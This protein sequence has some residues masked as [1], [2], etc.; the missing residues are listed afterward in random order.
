MSAVA[1]VEDYQLVGAGVGDPPVAASAGGCP[2]GID[3]LSPL[4]A[5]FKQVTPAWAKAWFARGE[6]GSGRVYQ[7]TVTTVADIVNTALVGWERALLFR[8][9]GHAEWAVAAVWLYLWC[10][11]SN[12]RDY[13]CVEVALVE[14]PLPLWVSVLKDWL[15]ALRRCP[16]IYAHPEI[17]PTDVL[18]LRALTSMANRT[19]E[20]ADWDDEI[21]K[22]AYQTPVHFGLTPEGDL[23]RAEWERLFS[24]IGREFA[25]MVVHNTSHAASL[26][27]IKD[28]WA[29]RWG[30]TPSGASSHGHLLDEIKER[31]PRL[32]ALA[33]AN[34]K[35]VF[36]ELPST[37]ANELITKQPGA[38]YRGS[39]KP[40]PGDKHRALLA[41]DDDMYIVGSYASVHVEKHMCERGVRAKQTPAD[42]ATWLQYDQLCDGIKRWLSLDYSDFNSEHEAASLTM[43]NVYLALEW[44]AA[45][46]DELHGEKACCALWVA[47]AHQRRRLSCPKGDFRLVGGLCSGDRDTARDNTLLHAIYS[48]IAVATAQVFD[49]QCRSG[50]PMF[51]GDDEDH[52]MP[53]WPSC[54]TYLMA[55]CIM[56]FSMK[57]EKQMCSVGTHEF[58][59]LLVVDHA[60][61]SRGLASAIAQ[62]AS[63]Q[64]Y[65]DVMLW[66]PNITASVSDNVWEMVRRG[67]PL[68]LARRL[69]G[70]HIGAMMRVPRP[71]GEWHQLEWWT[72]RHGVHGEHP[73]WVGT[74]GATAVLPELT[75]E[76]DPD[77]RAHGHATED[78]V[79]EKK[80]VISLPE[81]VWT[82]YRSHCRREGYNRLYQKEKSKQLERAVLR[83]WPERHSFQLDYQG[84]PAT[85]TPPERIKQL[86]QM[87]NV[88]RRPLVMSTMLARV[89]IDARL[90]GLAGGPAKVWPLL[91]TR[92]QAQ[93]SFCSEPAQPPLGIMY[94]D[95]QI[96]A[97]YCLTER[98]LAKAPLTRT[99]RI[100]RW[101]PTTPL[102]NP[103]TVTS[104]GLQGEVHTV[105]IFM[106]PNGCGKSTWACEHPL[107][108][109]TDEFCK[110]SQL[111]AE[112]HADTGLWPEL[113]TKQLV[114][115]IET[116]LLTRGATGIVTQLRLADVLAAPESRFFTVRIIVLL[117]TIEELLVRTASRGWAQ[118]KVLRRYARFLDAVR[119]SFSG[120]VLSARERAEA[121]CCPDWPIDEDISAP[122]SPWHSVAEGVKERWAQV[123]EHRMRTGAISR[124][125]QEIT[126]LP[127]LEVC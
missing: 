27:S 85:P 60:V 48:N 28:W 106:G 44:L 75:I 68:I 61:P 54:V 71:N 17:P 67:M 100:D 8:N 65:K 41:A 50:Y 94:Y 19:H 2:I 63:G 42:V 35:A 103:R 29:A 10:L 46:A 101:W 12:L 87:E 89:G 26:S 82:A 22:R 76:V 86:L 88:E 55:H 125:G 3:A 108:V 45:G 90:V 1:G 62:F 112:V 57:A 4:M 34:K 36:E 31:D 9:A 114:P 6:S 104:A 123:Q 15:T 122:D 25:R 121:R 116:M 109:D 24:S 13:L 59:R 77:S 47:L 126:T 16:I 58:L 84:M 37:Y 118:P 43:L 97:W 32:G 81:K 52:L 124:T 98:A 73:L 79:E 80:K 40:E 38:H 93:W 69:A 70:A 78:W 113:M 107:V 30:W 115:A 111:W 102:P 105:Y 110:K 14:M 33:R 99:E 117:P 92:A 127:L 120:T 5:E 91:K 21:R 64:W 72:Y 7:L 20:E 83:D 23:S 119:D 18:M 53:D 96:V 74:P 66:Y 49:E 95:A 39:T 51:T 11:P 56:G